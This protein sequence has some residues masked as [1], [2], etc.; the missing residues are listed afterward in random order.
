MSTCKVS[1]LTL[2]FNHAS[3]IKQNIEGFLSQKTSFPIELI[4]HDDCSTDGTADIIREYASRYPDKIHPI[5]QKENQY[6]KGVDPFDFLLEKATGE[7]YALCEGDD[8]WCDPNKLQKQVDFLDANRSYSAC[9]HNTEIRNIKTGK[10]S[11]LNP[12][13][14]SYDILL[15]DVIMVGSAS[16]HTSSLLVR[17]TSFHEAYTSELLKIY[18]YD[19]TVSI[20]YCLQGPIHFLPEIMSVYRLFS[21]ENA[22]SLNQ[23]R[24]TKEMEYNYLKHVEVM[25]ALD[26]LYKGQYR[27]LTEPVIVNYCQKIL[28]DYPVS[29]RWKV[30]RRRIPL[31]LRTVGGKIKRKIFRKK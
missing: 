30:Y 10:K 23:I 29:L 5:L 25:Y 12:K 9:V 15:K 8:Y 11:V 17:N 18:P 14:D 21:G 19:Y 26:R 7:Y 24:N 16:Y 22:W 6:S 1:V 2:A 20:L 27:E 31:R 13:N 4:I 28:L 3:Y